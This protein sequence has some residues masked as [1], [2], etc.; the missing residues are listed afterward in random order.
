[1]IGEDRMFNQIEAELLMYI[2]I[3]FFFLNS[4]AVYFT[5]K[6]F[7]EDMPGFFAFALNANKYLR[8]YLYIVQKNHR[9]P[10]AY[11]IWYVNSMIALVLFTLAVIITD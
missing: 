5:C 4:L 3:S 1:M 11:I 6:K 9:K 8:E 7:N 2:S 10:S